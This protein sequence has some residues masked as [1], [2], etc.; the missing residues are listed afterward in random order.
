MLIDVDLLMVVRWLR[1]KVT[2]TDCS[3]SFTFFFI[4]LTDMYVRGGVIGFR[5]M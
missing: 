2:S 4:K 5:K 3:N 1:I